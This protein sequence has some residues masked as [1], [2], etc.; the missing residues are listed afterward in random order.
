[1][2]PFQSIALYFLEKCCNRVLLAGSRVH[3][4]ASREC[5][6]KQNLYI[7]L[8][9]DKIYRLQTLWILPF[10]DEGVKS[11]LVISRYV[12]VGVDIWRV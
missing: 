6:S 10:S 12:F 4:E 2:G 9:E 8:H 7:V 11:S 3:R 1:M 5:T